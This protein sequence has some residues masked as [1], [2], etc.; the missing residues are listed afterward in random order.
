MVSPYPRRDGSD[1]LLPQGSRAQERQ[2]EPNAYKEARLLIQNE[3]M[4]AMQTKNAA[5]G[6]ANRRG[7]AHCQAGE[8]ALGAS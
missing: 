4:I 3:P 8:I 6:E 5:A 1:N 2:G 7:I